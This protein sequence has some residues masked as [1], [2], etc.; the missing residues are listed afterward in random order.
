MIHLI[1]YTRAIR[2][3]ERAS[4]ISRELRKALSITRSEIGADVV[5]D[6]RRLLPRYVPPTE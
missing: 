3:S 1:L 2:V 4:A 6:L 5:K